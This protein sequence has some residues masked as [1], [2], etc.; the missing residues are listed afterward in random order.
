LYKDNNIKEATNINF[1]A[2]GIDKNLNSRIHQLADN[3]KNFA[4]FDI[5][6]SSMELC[7]GVTLHH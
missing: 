5:P 3:A 1:L 2:M 7:S 6:H 4:Y